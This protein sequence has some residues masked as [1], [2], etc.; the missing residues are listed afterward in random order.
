MG[1]GNSNSL[2]DGPAFAADVLLLEVV[3]NTGLHLTIVDLPRLI[4]V[5]EDDE[6]VQLVKNLVDAYVEHSRT[7]ILAAVPATSD[8]DTQR[9]IQ[10][11]RHFDTT[12]LR[13]VGIITKPDLINPGTE[14][15]VA[16]TLIAQS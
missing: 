1:V 5:L 13:I 9:I 14:S 8:I 7:I 4:S 15:R 12:G 2:V 16:K 10:R 11:A 3:G 6:D